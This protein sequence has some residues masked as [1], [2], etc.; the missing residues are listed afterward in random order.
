[1]ILIERILTDFLTK[2]TSPQ[3]DYSGMEL[4]R[5]GQRAVEFGIRFG[6]KNIEQGM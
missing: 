3:L 4:K 2:V 1:M 6:M 5:F